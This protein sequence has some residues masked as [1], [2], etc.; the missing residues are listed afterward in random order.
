MARHGEEEVVA[1][2]VDGHA[3]ELVGQTF[4]QQAVGDAV[5]V[6]WVVGVGIGVGIGRRLVINVSVGVGVGIGNGAYAIAKHRNIVEQLRR[7]KEQIVIRGG[8]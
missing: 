6:L 1:R 2:T 7:D 4:H 8:T 5:I 3:S